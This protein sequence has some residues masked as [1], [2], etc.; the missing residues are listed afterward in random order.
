MNYCFIRKVIFIILIPVKIFGQTFTSYYTGSPFDTLTTPEGGVCLM[1]GAGEHDEAMKWFLKRSQKGDILVLRASGADGYN[2]YLFTELGVQVNSV[3]TIVFNNKSA[4]LESY[5]H[6]K[7][8]NAEA[9]WFAGGDQWDYISYWRNTA[10]DSLIND[11]IINRNIV[12]GGTS[13]GMAILGGYYFSA[14]YGTITSAEALSD[15]YTI[16]MTVDSALFLKNN[17]LRNVITDTHYDDPDRSGRHVGFMARII[18][19]WGKEAKGIGADAYSAL[20]IDTSGVAHCYGAYPKRNDYLYFLQTNCES[21]HQGPENCS[22][23]NPLEWNRGSKAIRVYK[24]NGT[25]SG[26]NTFNLKDWKSGNG[27]S[28]ENWYVNHG[29]LFKLPGNAIDCTDPTGIDSGLEENGI[30]IYPN[31]VT[32]GSFH[33]EC[34]DI[35]VKQVFICDGN[36][37]II[38]IFKGKWMNHKI[39]YT[40]GLGQGVY[41]LLV[42]TDRDFRSLKFIMP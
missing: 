34:P 11:G 14:R 33:L 15:P 42:E 27:G 32:G 17:Y 40:S 39:I 16:R 26:E 9:I 31:P 4:S 37:R 20:C 8:K 21:A 25:Q 22:S 29:V 1:G 24:I 5:I 19:D 18:T 7:I 13:A 23:G 3:E 30:N 2:N 38:K 28:W 6:Q 36:G 35:V 12:I 10:I 41:F